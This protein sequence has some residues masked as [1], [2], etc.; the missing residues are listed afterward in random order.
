MTEKATC[1]VRSIFYI[2]PYTNGGNMVATSRKSARATPKAPARRAVPEGKVRK[3]FWLDPETLAEAQ[4]FLGTASERE[5][6]EV[7]LDLVV[8]R[9][10]LVVGARALRRIQFTP[11]D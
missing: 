4:T 6:V 11:L 5:T 2:S 8:F 7:A 3:E 10:E 9:R 1:N